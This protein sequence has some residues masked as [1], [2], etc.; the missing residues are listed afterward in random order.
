MNSISFLDLSSKCGAETL[1]NVVRC[2]K[3]AKTDCVSDKL[4]NHHFSPWTF[5]KIYVHLFNTPLILYVG[6]HNF[7][8]LIFLLLPI[9]LFHLQLATLEKYEDVLARVNTAAAERMHALRAN[10]ASFQTNIIDVCPS[11]YVLAQ[12]LTH[13]E[14][15][16]IIGCQ[17]IIWRNV[18]PPAINLP[19]H[20][21]PFLNSQCASQT[22]AEYVA[23]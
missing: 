16:R 2:I 11:P 3:F 19:I 17:I 15:V 18:T 6:R 8:S 21:Q 14:L 23:E 12:Q 20:P 4:V 7:R 22:V 13:I 1:Q 9:C 10:P 5:C